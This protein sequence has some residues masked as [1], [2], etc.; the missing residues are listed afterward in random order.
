MSRLITKTIVPRKSYKGKIEYFARIVWEDADGTRHVKEKKGKNQTAARVIRD[1]L[2]ERFSFGGEEAINAE[3]M[4]FRE[5]AEKYKTEKVVP[6]TFVGE[7]KVAGHKYPEKL[8]NQVDRLVKYFGAMRVVD[9]ARDYDAVLRFK[10]QLIETPTQHKRQRSMHDVNNQ[11][12]TLRMMLNYAK[13]KGWIHRTPF[14]IGEP[15][16]NPADELPRFREEQTGEIEKLLSKC[17]GRRAHIRPWII[18]AIETAARPGEV[19]HIQRQDLFFEEKMIRLRQST[20]KTNR[21]RWVPMTDYLSKELQAWL[22]FVA[23][24]PYW[25]RRISKKPEAYIFGGYQ[26][27]KTAFFAAC[28]EAGIHDLQRKDLRK[29]GTT[30][31]VAA[32]VKAGIP[33]K[34][35]MAIT[36]HTQEKTFQSYIITAKKVVQSAGEALE[37]YRLEKTKA[38]KGIEKKGE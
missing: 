12:R 30:N 35:A 31:L 26:S 33:E 15:L 3:Q 10:L 23:K 14:E 5:L 27:N 11:L 4:T 22:E 6:A 1:R 19:D 20:T 2:A 7:R 24:D 13:R 18:T 34:H 25:K 8:E 16:I 17:T 32:F 21:E 36:G 37:K 28:E 29:F 38:E 9:L